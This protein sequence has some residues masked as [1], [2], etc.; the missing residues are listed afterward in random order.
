MIEI[1][2]LV[3]LKSEFRGISPADIRNRDLM[4]EDINGGLAVVSYHLN[5]KEVNFFHKAPSWV[6]NPEDPSIRVVMYS[7]P[8]D[9]LEV[10]GEK[11][12]EIV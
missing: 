4:V 2:S 8:L 3:K 10:I 6:A 5:L 1:G 11:M 7:V 9:F 12:Q